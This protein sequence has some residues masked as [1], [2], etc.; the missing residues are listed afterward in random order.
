MVLV[1]RTYPV[2]D[3]L[4]KTET[5]LLK[6]AFYV[7]YITFNVLVDNILMTE[8]DSIVIYTPNMHSICIR[9][10][11]FPNNFDDVLLTQF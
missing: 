6:L 1:Y 8:D 2:L 5:R 7:N 10:Y 4:E 9:K 11:D 3:G